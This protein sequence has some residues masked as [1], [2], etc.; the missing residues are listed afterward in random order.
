MQKYSKY[1]Y[2]F[3]HNDKYFIFNSI[4]HFFAELDKEAFDELKSTE[5]CI[6]ED[7]AKFPSELQGAKIFLSEEEEKDE[8]NKI[9]YATYNRRFQNRHA[10]F[11]I[12]PTYQCNYNCIYCYEESRPAVYMDDT[13]EN[14]LV[15]LVKQMRLDGFHIT[16]FGGEP[17]LNFKRIKSLT[18]KILA[19]GINYDADIITNGYLLTEDKL[20][21]FEKLRISSIQLTID[22][23]KEEHDKRRPHVSGASSFDKIMENLDNFFSKERN[24]KMNIRV[25]IDKNNEEQFYYLYSLLKNNYPKIDI[26]PS[27][28]FIKD[29]N[30]ASYANCMNSG[31]EKLNFNLEFAKKMDKPFYVY[32]E[33]RPNECIAR[34]AF[35]FV[36]GAN[37]DIF[38]CYENIGNAEKRIGNINTN[39][40]NFE[41]YARWIMGADPLTDEKCLDCKLIPV[42]H[43]ACPML[44]LE[45][46]HAGTEIYNPC[47]MMKDIEEKILTLH[48]EQKEIYL[49][50][51]QP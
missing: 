36:I 26:S 9:K 29:K 24:I 48:L 51:K 44:R 40:F 46:E 43:G 23:I 6:C 17:L 7:I 38:K 15:E 10:T 16:W 30:C 13:T 50:Q 2:L 32:P 25:N 37:G 20:S 18:E 1:N 33:Q 11:V 8:L 22:G 31:L 19:L 39:E 27:F 42:C 12:T 21:M 28:V 45:N 35:S 34:S 4:S 47:H 5:S 49:K 3:Q 41:L 14:N